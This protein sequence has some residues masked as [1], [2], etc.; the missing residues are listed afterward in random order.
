MKPGYSAQQPRLRWAIVIAM[1][2]LVVL[3]VSWETALAPLR[4]GAWLLGLKGLPVLL[5]LPGMLAGR[6]R[7][8]QWW[9]MLSMIYLAEGLV[10]GTT[11]SGLS[12]QLAWAEAGLATLIFLMVLAWCKIVRGP[13]VSAAR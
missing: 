13:K 2:A 7:T 11:E 5:A 6:I 10:R 3:C 8:F 1:W 4:E 9:S 12:A